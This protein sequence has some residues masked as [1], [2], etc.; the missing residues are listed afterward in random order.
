MKLHLKV[1]LE[2]L[3]RN[4]C[5]EANERCYRGPEGKMGDAARSWRLGEQNEGLGGG[6]RE[7]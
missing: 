5:L 2:L 6:K 7:W 4:P 1:E 3:K